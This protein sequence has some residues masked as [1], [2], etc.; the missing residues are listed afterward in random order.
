LLEVELLRFAL[1]RRINI[2]VVDIN[3][4]FVPLVCQPSRFGFT[5]S[6]TPALAAL[7]VNPHTNPNDYVFWDDFHPT[8]KAH[9]IAAGF[10][11]KAMFSS[12][13]LHEFLSLR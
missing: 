13:H 4:I 1:L 10:I 5:N 2:Q 9:C 11:Y 7:A 8:T 6:I 3:A 12:R